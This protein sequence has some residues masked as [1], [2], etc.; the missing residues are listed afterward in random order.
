MKRG[1]TS[2]SV[3]VGM[4]SRARRF[5]S[6]LRKKAGG[7]VAGCA[8]QKKAGALE[9]EAGCRAQVVNRHR[10]ERDAHKQHVERAL[11]DADFDAAKLAKITAETLKIRQ[12]AERRAWGL[13]PS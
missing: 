5:R 3:R 6:G 2:L 13:D 4:A 1:A 8:P 9:A 12:E 11:T 7:V 10:D